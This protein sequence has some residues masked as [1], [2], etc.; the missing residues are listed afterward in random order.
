MEKQK[1]KKTIW[2]FAFASFLND[3]GADMVYSIWPIFVASFA[4]ANMA[5][6]G[7]IDGVGNA[8]VS[9]SQAVSGYI[10]DRIKK[11]KIFIA[12]GYFF[13]GISKLGYALSTS[14]QM[15]IPLR[16]LDRSGKMRDAPRDAIMAEVSAKNTRAKN[17]G[18]LKAMDHLGAVF[19]VILCIFLFEKLGFKNLFLLAA[20]PPILGSLLVVFIIK[21]KKTEKIF[22]GIHLRDFNKNFLLFITLSSIFSLA[23]FSYSFLLIFAKSIGFSNTYLPL[24]YLTFNIIS[25][26]MSVPFGKLSDKMGRKKVMFLS[27]FFWILICIDFIL[28]N[29]K[30]SVFLGFILYGLHFAALEPSQS[31]LA[32]EICSK[33][34][35]A[36]SIG[37]LRMFIGLFA[38]PASIIAGILWEGVNK[39]AP[40]YFSII[41]TL[42]SGFLLLFVSEKNN[43]KKS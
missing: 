16:I 2:T 13:G 4:G 37:T 22:E 15:L 36:S 28:F 7:L 12:L 30:L 21:E 32:S 11:R 34:Y 18:I 6:L 25:S 39:T 3:L 41:I 29:D 5:V 38:L 20:V 9:I 40:F 27:M 33:K 1:T 23:L 24:L 8:V 17:F 42:I 19:G 43:T 26:A 35:R 10:S 31:A 14:W